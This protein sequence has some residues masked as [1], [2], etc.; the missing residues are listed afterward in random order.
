VQALLG[1]FKPGDLQWVLASMPV[2]SDPGGFSYDDPNDFVD[3]QQ[4]FAKGLVDGMLNMP[5]ASAAPAR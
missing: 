2:A 5:I 4:P 3:S 1:G